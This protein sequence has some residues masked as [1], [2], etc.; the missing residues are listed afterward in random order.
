MSKSNLIECPHCGQIIFFG[1]KKQKPDSENVPSEKQN[2]DDNPDQQKSPPDFNKQKD[3]LQR[4]ISEMEKTIIEMC[5]KEG[6]D[7]MP[8]YSGIPP[9]MNRKTGYMYGGENIWLLWQKCKEKDY[10]QNKWA[11]FYQ[12]SKMGAKIKKGEKGALIKL[13]IPRNSSAQFELDEEGFEYQEKES[14]GFMVRYFKVFNP[15]QVKDWYEGTEQLPIFGNPGANPYD[16]IDRMINNLGIKIHSGSKKAEYLPEFDI[17]NMPYK[18]HF[19][20][21]QKRKGKDAYYSILLQELIE[22]TG[23]ELR[24]NR[25][26]KNKLT[27]KPGLAFE[28]MIAEL[29]GAM[30][31][32]YF[33]KHVEVRND[34]FIYREIWKKIISHNIR[35]LYDAQ[36]QALSAITWILKESDLFPLVR[37]NEKPFYPLSDKQVK[38]IENITLEK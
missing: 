26:K 14:N 6:S 12:W 21:N 28:K 9:A 15:D 35:Y 32:S 13:Y 25:V 3:E 20:D 10:S 29:G 5:K 34:N 23:H 24:F 7:Q 33:H 2:E 18:A 27:G 4:Q 17:I 22:W 36:N 19:A 37:I 8:W 31:S 1:V 38:E 30:L 11:T 16:S